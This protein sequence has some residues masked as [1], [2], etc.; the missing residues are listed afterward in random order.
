MYEITVEDEH[1]TVLNVFQYQS[2]NEAIRIAKEA[3][4]HEQG[5]AVVSSENVI[6]REFKFEDG[7]VNTYDDEGTQL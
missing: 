3:A 1:G 5:R 4:R 7:R 6:D 2:R